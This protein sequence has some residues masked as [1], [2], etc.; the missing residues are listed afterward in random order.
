MLA[1]SGSAAIAV[2]AASKTDKVNALQKLLLMV[3]LPK[4]DHMR[5]FVG[6]MF[7]TIV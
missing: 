1:A 6:A 2:P 4:G 5:R 3:V 7:S